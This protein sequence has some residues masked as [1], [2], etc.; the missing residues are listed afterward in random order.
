VN[1]IHNSNVIF[2]T[3]VKVTE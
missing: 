2:L 1:R 3:V